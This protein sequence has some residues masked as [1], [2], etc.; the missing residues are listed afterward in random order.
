MSCHFNV[1]RLVISGLSVA[2]PQLRLLSYRASAIER[3]LCPLA[4]IVIT[5]R[6]MAKPMSKAVMSEKPCS[7]FDRVQRDMPLL[8]IQISVGSLILE[9]NKHFR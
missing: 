3:S 9:A 5:T 7:L 8:A 6:T 2:K 4:V 1:A